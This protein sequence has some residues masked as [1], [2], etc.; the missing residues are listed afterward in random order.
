MKNHELVTAD[1]EMM[2]TASDAF[3]RQFI[4][5]ANS[6][7]INADGWIPVNV[8]LPDEPNTDS[9]MK[10]YNVTIVGAEE[11]TTLTYVGHG[12]WHDE[13]DNRYNVLAWQPLPKPFNPLN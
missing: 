6:N 12:K 1:E 10:E 4:K 13:N 3:F 8:C 5:W 11:S 2:K 7:D 9:E